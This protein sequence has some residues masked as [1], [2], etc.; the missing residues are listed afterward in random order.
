MS[1]SY[2]VAITRYDDPALRLSSPSSAP[3]P[4]PPS[5]STSYSY[6]SPSAYPP[7]PSTSSSSSAFRSSKQYIA[8]TIPIPL[9]SH[10]HILALT[11]YRPQYAV[12]PLENFGV[13]VALTVKRPHSPT[14][15]PGGSNASGVVPLK[16][17]ASVKR[18][19]EVFDEEP[20]TDSKGRSRGGGLLSRG[21]SAA[22]AP[23]PSRTGSSSNTTAPAIA[24][25]PVRE[26]GRPSLY[27]SPP[28]QDTRRSSKRQRPPTAPTGS[29]PSLTPSSTIPQAV[30]SE[31]KH[32]RHKSLTPEMERQLFLSSPHHHKHAI[33]PSTSPEARTVMMGSG[34]SNGTL[35]GSGSEEEESSDDG[36]DE[37]SD[38]GLGPESDGMVAPMDIDPPPP[39][40]IPITTPVVPQKS[41]GFSLFEKRLWSSKS[42]TPSSPGEEMG[43]GLDEASRSSSRKDKENKKVDDSNVMRTLLFSESASFSKGP[44][45]VGA[46]MQSFATASN[47]ATRGQEKGSGE[48]LQHAGYSHPQLRAYAL[49]SAPTPSPTRQI[50]DEA[51]PKYP[52]S[53]SPSMNTLPVYSSTTALV[54]EE[55]KKSMA[56][57]A[58][59]DTYTSNFQLH[60]PTPKSS[61]HWATGETLTTCMGTIKFVIGCKVGFFP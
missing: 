58:G 11:T 40:S 53:A 5:T 17:V 38:L 16:V 49:I 37:D 27:P 19:V 33:T 50:S 54:P 10:P 61:H 2:D 55:E 57:M 31:D 23:S 59:G 1:K 14:S 22:A 4:S 12:G 29:R 41:S 52:G 60:V 3:L 24:T 13:T 35:V 39:T 56:M 7:P 28:S 48:P 9:S 46:L 36:E 15:S 34:S 44:V 45:D 18:V 32:S 20:T 30:S 26:D 8:N 51:L 6:I 42:G 21:F 25:A 43:L 47:P